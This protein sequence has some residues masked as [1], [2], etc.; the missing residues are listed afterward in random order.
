MRTV[1]T[2]KHFLNSKNDLVYQALKPDEEM[3]DSQLPNTFTVYLKF[4][5]SAINHSKSQSAETYRKIKILKLMKSYCKEYGNEKR[6]LIPK[7]TFLENL[8]QQ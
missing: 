3:Y 7:L 8:K 4:I 2:C 5:E 1:Q 6:Q